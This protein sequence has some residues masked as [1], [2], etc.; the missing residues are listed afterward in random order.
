M[1]PV[2]FFRKIIY[3][4]A[5]FIDKVLGNANQV[6]VIAL[7]SFDEDNWRFSIPFSKLDKILNS[8]ISHGYTFITLS[9][10]KE[11]DFSNSTGKKILITIDDGYKNN[12]RAVSIFKKYEIKPALSIISGAPDRNELDNNLELLSKEDIVYLKGQG[13][14]IGSHS[15]THANFSKLTE[16]ES[17]D[18]VEE[19]MNYISS[20]IG[21]KP[22]FFSYP[23]GNVLQF[24]KELIKK[25]GYEIAFSM[26]DSLV[27]QSTDLF[28][29]P[30]VGLDASHSV[31]EA[32][33]AVSPSSI[34]FRS[35]VKNML[36]KNLIERYI[37]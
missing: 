22:S 19:S 12:I 30:R 26:N 28:M 9:D 14:D 21:E 1:N 31:F 33:W 34:K 5:Y 36:S 20:V 6:V 29:F 4:I 16:M 37:K 13:W 11:M 32:T 24:Q 18:E 23:K 25:A 7:H 8:F 10:L 2:L 17:K 3:L 27:D 35:F 15:K